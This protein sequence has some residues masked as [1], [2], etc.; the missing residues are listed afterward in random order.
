MYTDSQN[1][2]KA[3]YNTQYIS[4]QLV[5]VSMYKPNNKQAETFKKPYSS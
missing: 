3:N 5:R 2:T 4:Y 1:Y